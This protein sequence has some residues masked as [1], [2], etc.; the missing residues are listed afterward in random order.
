MSQNQASNHGFLDPNFYYDTRGHSELTINSLVKFTGPFEYFGFVNYTGSSE[1]ADVG[2]FFSEQTLRWKF[3]KELPFNLAF[4]AVLRN[5]DVND[6]Y[7]LGARWIANDTDALTEF[8]AK[9]HFNYAVTVYALQAGY[10]NQETW[11]VQIEH[12]Y[13]LS[14]WGN[15]VYLSGFGDQNINHDKDNPF[16]WV[17]E[18]Q[19][20]IQLLKNTYVVAEYRINEF[21]NDVMGVGLGLEYVVRF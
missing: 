9:L 16:T 20:G 17:T 3:H 7:R 1:N 12:A 14:F 6:S 10:G 11:L 4:Q 19:L 2:T 8:L 15:R 21:R 13:R 18:H 5:G